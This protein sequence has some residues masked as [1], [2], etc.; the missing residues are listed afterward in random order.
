VSTCNSF[1]KCNLENERGLI[2]HREDIVFVLSFHSLLLGAIPGAGFG[3]VCFF[4]MLSFSK[5]Y[6]LKLIQLRLK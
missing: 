2:N 5:C 6:L 4:G 3:M 1:G